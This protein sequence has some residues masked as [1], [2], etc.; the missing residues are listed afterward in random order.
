MKLAVTVILVLSFC[1]TFADRTIWY[2]H[3]DS[4]L[5]TIQAGLD[6][7]AD[8]DIVLVAPGTYMES[9]NWPATAGI[10]LISEMGVELSIIDGDSLGS[11]FRIVTAVD[12]TTLIRGFTIQNGCSY[13]GGGLYIESGSSPSIVNNKIYN[14]IADAGGGIGCMFNASPIIRQNIFIGNMADFGGAILCS[15]QS[16]PFIVDN[17]ISDN[18][19][20][21]EGGGIAVSS[22]SAPQIKGNL[23]SNNTAMWGAGIYSCVNSSPIIDSCTISNNYGDGFSVNWGSSGRINHTNIYGNSGFGVWKYEFDP[24][25][26][27]AEYNWWGDASGPYHP[28]S[29]PGGLGDSVSDWVDF[30]PWLDQPV[31]VEEQK[32]TIPINNSIF[33]T[34]ISCGPLLLPVDKSCRVFDITGRVILP[35][36]IK[37][38][39][40]F[41]EVDGKVTQKVIKIR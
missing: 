7:C 3:P 10:H 41:I 5:N 30:I 8:N 35:D 40:Y 14:N 37:P 2:V 11:V 31:G 12:S 18:I 27:D 32:L 9:I 17:Q 22:Y 38:G 25:P 28:D 19:A 6:S 20:N 15:E 21:A 33:S 1:L 13:I 16:H 29:N 36:K 24:D 26:V 23:I 4:T 39:I 34:T